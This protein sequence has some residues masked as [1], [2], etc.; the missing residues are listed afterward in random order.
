MVA[1]KLRYYLIIYFYIYFI[2]KYNSGFRILAA[3]NP[4]YRSDTLDTGQ[5]DLRTN[6]SALG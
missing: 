4:E 2:V 5:N 1:S 3:L 6:I